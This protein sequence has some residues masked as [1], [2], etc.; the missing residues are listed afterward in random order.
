[1]REFR[2]GIVAIKVHRDPFNPGYGE[3][4]GQQYLIDYINNQP[5]VILT[6]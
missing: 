6:P 4:T 2:D 1:M 5:H 3:Q